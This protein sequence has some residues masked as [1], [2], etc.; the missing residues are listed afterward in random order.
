MD[1]N[2][3]GKLE[4]PLAGSSERSENLIIGGDFSDKTLHL[5]LK[6]KCANSIEMKEQVHESTCMKAQIKLA[7]ND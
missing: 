6:I 3:D 4:L 1:W 5:D 2:E 7:K